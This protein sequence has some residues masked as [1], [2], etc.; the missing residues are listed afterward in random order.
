MEL[1]EPFPGYSDLVDPPPPPPF[2][3][4]HSAPFVSFL[5][6]VEICSVIFIVHLLSAPPLDCA[7]HGGSLLQ[8]PKY[9]LHPVQFWV[10]TRCSTN[11]CGRRNGTE[12]KG[13]VVGE[14]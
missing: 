6:S 13:R 2:I 4:S 12:K 9:S 5:G 7:L 3:L 8:A 11:V 10:H 1:E 14:A